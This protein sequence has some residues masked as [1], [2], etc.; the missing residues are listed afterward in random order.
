MGGHAVRYYGLERNTIDFDL[1]LAPEAWSGIESLVRTLPLFSAGVTAGNSWRPG[2]FQRYQIGRLPDGREEWLEFWRHNHLLAPFPEL[3]ERRETGKYGGQPLPFMALPDLIR[4]K[5]TERLHDWHDV[6]IL[7]E[8]L[9]ARN[10]SQAKEG[11]CATS[12]VFSRLRS[13][14]GL[15]A[16]HAA[17]L[18]CDR[19][20]VE[21]ALRQTQH[22]V[23]QALLL[24][25]APSGTLAQTEP[26]IEQLVEAR[27]RSASPLL[28]LHLTLVE[29]VRRQYRNYWMAQDR[30]DKERIR[31]ALSD[32]AT[33]L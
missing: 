21:S 10:L 30:A 20:P 7:E 23:T 24:P 27:L 19:T 12:D 22:P 4:S 16:L 28:A 18:L 26:P 13:R 25:F 8:F 3:Y 29:A 1:H 15:E 11:A 5:E 33:E 2:D 9:D 32:G 17:G 31:K 6:E 14:K